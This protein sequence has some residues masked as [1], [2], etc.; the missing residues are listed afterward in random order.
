MGL[1][2]L[3]ENIVRQRRIKGVTQEELADFIGVT[4]ASVS[5]WETGTTTP[6][7]QILPQIASFFDVT[8]DR[9][10]GYEPQLGKEQIKLY[11]HRLAEEF[12]D[13]SFEAVM[14]KSEALVKRYY[15]CYPFLEQMAVLWMNH[16]CLAE[17][18]E[19]QQEVIEKAILLCDRIIEN[20]R[21][22]GMCDNAVAL[23]ALMDLQLNRPEKVI[24]AFEEEKMDV[25]R[26]E[27]KGTLLT[28]AYME[29]G[30]LEKAEKASQIG[31]Y[32]STMDLLGYG[33]HLMTVRGQDKE[34]CLEIIKRLDAIM[35][36]FE[37]ERL[38]PNTA[39][40]C[41]YRIAVQLCGYLQEGDKEWEECVY[42]RLEK[43]IAAVHRL[44]ADGVRLHGDAFFSKL[45]EWI[46]DLYLGA[47]SVR[48][49][50]SVW[51]SA[52]EG[53]EHPVFLALSDRTRMENYKKR[54]QCERQAD[55]DYK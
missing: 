29:V 12:A 2:N 9:L 53:L 19:R 24:E 41:H 32:R 38:N 33:L 49:E 51:K 10:L 23:K 43:Y 8:V 25:N 1:L 28:L 21:N 34:Y 50:K 31:M 14:E 30:N 18:Q 4:K 11:Y 47:D 36:A 52:V 22:I 39:A 26:I 3:A 54:L 40:G 13:G 15:C 5:K 48:S 20:S 55:G 17:T 16:A 45:D 37:L 44:F 27:D 7:I 46:A 35:N 42:Q 6:D